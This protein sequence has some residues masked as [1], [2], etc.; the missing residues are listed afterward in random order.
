ME[1]DNNDLLNECIESNENETNDYVIIYYYS[2]N[3]TMYFIK[4][5]DDLNVLIQI[6]ISE[7]NKKENKYHCFGLFACVCM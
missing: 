1:N 4:H 7:M 3:E 5:D 6:K 2:K